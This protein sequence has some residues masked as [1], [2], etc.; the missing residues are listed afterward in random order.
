MSLLL[1]SSK[2]PSSMQSWVSS[3]QW[4]VIWTVS[5]LEGVVDALEIE[6]S[7]LEGGESGPGESEG[8][9]ERGDRCNRAFGG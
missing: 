2:I 8:L 9:L 6:P 7:L 5:D 4:S 1:L 3:L